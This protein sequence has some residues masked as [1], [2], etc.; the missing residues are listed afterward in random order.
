MISVSF[1]GHAAIRA[2][3]NPVSDLVTIETVGEYMG[4]KVS[5]ISAT[6][7]LLQRISINETVFKVK[8]GS[9][10]PGMYLLT[11]PD[12]KTVRLFKYWLLW[13]H[14]LSHYSS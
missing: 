14:A 1:T 2:F 4:A 9:Y 6:G 10:A 12:G 7:V 3:P 13:R 8:L 11:F 5:L